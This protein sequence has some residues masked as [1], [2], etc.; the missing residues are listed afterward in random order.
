MYANY[1]KSL[2]GRSE[3][4]TVLPKPMESHSEAKTDLP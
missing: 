4:K 1:L 2:E 3:T